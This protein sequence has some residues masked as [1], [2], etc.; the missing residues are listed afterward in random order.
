MRSAP[1]PRRGSP[2]S[3]PRGTTTSV[4]PR[5]LQHLL[6]DGGFA[7][8]AF[9]R[10]Y[11]GAGLTLDHQ[12]AFFDEAAAQDRQVPTGNIRVS[13]GM[14]GPTLLEYGSEE[15]KRRFLPPLLRG[16][17]LW[18]QLLSEPQGGSDMAGAR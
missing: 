15:A 9:P 6:F 13:I 18:M 5:S 3:C 14:L 16:D 8:I 2:S 7:G 4:E 12:K 11:G 10:A 1:G 17:A